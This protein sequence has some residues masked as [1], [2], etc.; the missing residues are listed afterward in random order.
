MGQQISRFCKYFRSKDSKVYQQQNSGSLSQHRSKI[1]VQ[2]NSDGYGSESEQPIHHVRQ[3][4]TI[5]WK[6]GEL[7]GQGSF[8]RV[9]KC[10]DINS[11][12]ILAVKQ[13][14][15]GYVDKESLESFRQEIQILSQ[16]KHKNIVEYYGCEEDDKNLSILLEFVG[17]G[18]IAQMMR[19]FKSKLSESIIQKYVTD[20]LHGLFYLHHKG[21]IH[22]DIKGANIIVD[23]KG[24]CKL[25]DFGCSIIGQSAYS[26]KGTPNWM[27]PEVINQQETGRYSDIWSLGCTIIEMLTS[28]PPWGKFQSPMQALLTIS[29]KQCSPPIPNNIS[30]QLKDFLNKCL[31]FDHKKRW[32]ARKLLKHP[33][34]INFNKK[35][36]KGESNPSQFKVFEEKSDINLF[37][38]PHIDDP[39]KDLEYLDKEQNP[40]IFSVQS[41][42]FH[43]ENH[44]F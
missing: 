30:D 34:I 1:L 24:V 6:K 22:R 9:F 28:E 10:M 21:I 29:S 8:G 40:M 14:A 12:R 17:G 26:L 44:N 18:S 27:A 39:R 20:I 42:G 32:Q 16:L 13:I 5:K 3:S 38:A 33:F 31:Q 23:T 4:K 43:D 19:K 2:N 25:A 37:V 7:I 11:G 41:S 36:S 15:L 35:P